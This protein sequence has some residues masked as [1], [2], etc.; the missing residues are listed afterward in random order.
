LRSTLALE[1]QAPG[2]GQK[3][4]TCVKKILTRSDLSLWSVFTNISSS[5][6]DC[7]MFLG[8]T[9]LKFQW[10]KVSKFMICVHQHFVQSLWLYDVSGYDYYEISMNRAPFLFLNGVGHAVPS[11][12]I[13]SDLI[14]SLILNSY[15]TSCIC[16]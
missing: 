15:A 1:R 3:I 12:S 4:H 10:I 5:H 11:I 2:L 16:R 9:A 7:M 6:Y 14:L 13:W 8:K